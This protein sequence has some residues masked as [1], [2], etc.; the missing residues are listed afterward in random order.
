MS[1]RSLR[2][3]NDILPEEIPLWREAE[4]KAR[5]L[6]ARY[7]YEEIRTPILEEAALFTRTLGETT[8]IVEKEMYTFQDHGEKSVSLRPEGTASV[9][10]AFIESGR[11]VQDP[12]AR[13]FYVGPMYRHERPQ[14]G[15]LRQFHQIGVEAFGIASP[16]FD[17]E[18]IHMLDCFFQNL[19]LS[20]LEIE[21]NSLG[22]PLCRPKYQKAFHEY[23]LQKQADLCEDCK[24]RTVKNPLR[25]LDCREE[26]CR[27]VSE[28]A[29]SIQ[30][31]LCDS[32]ERDFDA[33]LSNLGLLGSGYKVNNRIVRGLDYYIK[34]TFE[35]TSPRL[36]AQNAVAGGGRYDGLVRL[37]GGPNI[38]G[39]GFAIGIERLVDLLKTG[40][41]ADRVKPTRIFMA[42]LGDKA[43]QE[44]FRLAQT[45]RN[46]GLAVDL[47][48]EGKSLKSQLRRADRTGASHVLILGD[49]ELQRKTIVLRDMA[50]QSQ[51]ELP[52]DTALQRLKAVSFDCRSLL[53]QD[54]VS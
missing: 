49:N 1:I 22:C 27:A 14:K 33:V 32:C 23:L 24:K 35:F 6:F 18:M 21:I 28:E 4:K 46:E 5:T 12:V 11:A 54:S 3:M 19:G 30:E 13:Y 48:Y 51:E 36:G 53:N 20:D 34:T 39:V 40:R 42:P 8:N 50:A 15:R 29:P 37:M 16:L 7:G 47:D 52:P 41:G 31:F 2:G 44:A 45:L 17:A 10:R 43:L 25:V 9:V 26:K 38:P